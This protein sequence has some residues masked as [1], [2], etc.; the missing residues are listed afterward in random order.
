MCRY[1]Y[2]LHNIIG[3]YGTQIS[4]WGFYIL[5][6]LE[7]EE[8]SELVMFYFTTWSNFGTGKG[9]AKAPKA[10]CCCWVKPSFLFDGPWVGN[11]HGYK[12]VFIQSKQKLL[13]QNQCVYFFSF[14]EL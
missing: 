8:G 5:K 10:Q 9:C 4:S 13:S 7:S 12:N 11:L 6:S 3:A 2:A 1:F 14:I